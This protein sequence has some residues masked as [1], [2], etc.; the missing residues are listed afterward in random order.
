MFVYKSI[1]LLKAEKVRNST[2]KLRIV[3]GWLAGSRQL[4]VL[5]RR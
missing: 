3:L 1:S 2:V 4:G 5:G